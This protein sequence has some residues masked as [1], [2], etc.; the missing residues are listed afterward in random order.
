V[1][2]KSN[3]FAIAKRL[4]L[5]DGIIASARD[6][7]TGENI[8]F[9]DVITDLEISRKQVEIEE[10]RASGLRREAERM[11]ADLDNQKQRLE[12]SK[13]RVLEEAKKEA[14]ALVAKA[15]NE[16]DSIV[17]EMQKFKKENLSFKEVEEGRRKLRE[18]LNE[19]E[20]ASAA[21]DPKL[22]L[23]AVD[24]PL[25]A[26]DEVYI[27]SLGQRAVII[28]V[29]PAATEA[30]VQFGSMETKVKMSDLRLEAGKKE[31]K[32]EAGGV[33]AGSNAF[34]KSAKALSISAK[35]DLRGRLVEEALEELGKYLDDAYLA[36]MGKIEIIHGKGTGALR[37]AVQRELRGHPHIKNYRL[38]EF[39][40]GDSGVTIV[41]LH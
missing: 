19:L 29:N 26:G 17:R 16:A 10:E 18:Q 8:R 30:R 25:A 39:G 32:R 1:P 9:E 38:G 12:R 27:N 7:L 6:V 4:G 21:A 22:S 40:E 15:K 31:K 34:V 13:E 37:A 33:A 20:T 36:G 5:P 35:L 14:R 2:G 41:E 11:A 24:R 28:S 3:A 23:K